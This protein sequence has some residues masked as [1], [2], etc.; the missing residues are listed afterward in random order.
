MENSDFIRAFKEN[1]KRLMEIVK[2]VKRRRNIEELTATLKQVVRVNISN[3][4][5]VTS[6]IG[7]YTT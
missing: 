4:L 5:I 7:V 6:L 1:P 3:A 2:E